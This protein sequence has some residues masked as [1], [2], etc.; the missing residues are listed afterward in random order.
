MN[1]TKNYEHGVQ[2]LDALMAG[3]EIANADLVNASAENLTF[4]MVQKGRKGRELTMRVQL[5][6]VNA[7]NRLFPDEPVKPADLFNYRGR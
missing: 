1:E 2:P 7:L 3:R 6:I 5:K 4:K